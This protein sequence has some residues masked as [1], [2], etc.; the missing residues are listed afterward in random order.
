MHR[1]SK[2]DRETQRQRGMVADPCLL[3]HDQN[4]FL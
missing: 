3:K 4:G 1:A 2:T